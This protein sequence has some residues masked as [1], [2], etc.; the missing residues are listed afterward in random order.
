MKLAGGER[1]DVSCAFC[2]AQY[3]SPSFQ[4]VSCFLNVSPLR[5]QWV[6]GGPSDFH[7]QPVLFPHHHHHLHLLPFCLLGIPNNF[8]QSTI[9]RDQ[10]PVIWE[11]TLGSQLYKI[12]WQQKVASWEGGL[13]CSVF[14]LFSCYFFPSSLQDPS[15]RLYMIFGGWCGR[16]TVS[17]SSWSRSWW[18]LAGYV[19]YSL[20][21]SSLLSQ[22]LCSEA[23]WNHQNETVWCL[24]E[25]LFF[26]FEGH[27]SWKTLLF[28]QLQPKSCLFWV[29]MCF[30]LIQK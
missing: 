6:T 3:F 14:W 9:F 13:W 15:R 12:S 4:A 2:L 24:Y 8:V 1:K 25:K 19:I 21:S 30:R 17:A 18:R 5:W 20:P 16:K 11:R 28:K 26:V 23:H 10:N 29:M 22:T 7:H 27:M